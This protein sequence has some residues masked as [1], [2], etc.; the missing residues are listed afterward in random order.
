MQ[1]ISGWIDAAGVCIYRVPTELVEAYSNWSPSLLS[2]DVP[3]LNLSKLCWLARIHYAN[4]KGLS[5]TINS[6]EPRG[7]WRSG[8]IRWTGGSFSSDQ[9]QTDVVS[10]GKQSPVG[11][12][13][14]CMGLPV[15]V[16]DFLAIR[17]HCWEPIPPPFPHLPGNHIIIII[18]ARSCC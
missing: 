16:G 13:T 12:R 4:A 17:N 3:S 11:G 1:T 14:P 15:S 7:I 9:G 2:G 8:C 10:T 6:Y 18:A 5:D